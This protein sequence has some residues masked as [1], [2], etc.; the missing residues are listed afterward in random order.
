MGRITKTEMEMA[1]GGNMPSVPPIWFRETCAV[2]AKRTG[3]DVTTERVAGWIGVTRQTVSAY[4]N[5][6][7]EIPTAVVIAMRCILV[8][9]TE[10]GKVDFD[11]KRSETN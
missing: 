5:G 4:R 7:T 6:A 9:A 10:Y 3:E 8:Y 2:I 11:A 1:I